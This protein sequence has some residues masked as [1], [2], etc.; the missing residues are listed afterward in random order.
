MNKQIEIRT[1]IK[2]LLDAVAS[3]VYYNL[4]P[5]NATMPYVVFDLSNAVTDGSLETSVL[6]VDVWD[7]S[8]D[9]TVLETLVGNIDDA[10]NK[11]HVLIPDKIAFGIYRETRMNV[12]DTE[13]SVKRRKYVYQIRVYEKYYNI[14]GS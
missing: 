1:A 9:T 5:D 7:D 2:I 4:A 12:E 11:R 13:K 14:G 8:M 3:R 6:D 10:I